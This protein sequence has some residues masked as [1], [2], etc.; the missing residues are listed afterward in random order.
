MRQTGAQ[1][2]LRTAAGA[3]ARHSGTPG[4]SAVGRAIPR[5]GA[6]ASAGH[7]EQGGGRSGPGRGVWLLVRYAEETGI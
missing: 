5:P 2:R 1:R 4:P 7:S 6:E 3:L